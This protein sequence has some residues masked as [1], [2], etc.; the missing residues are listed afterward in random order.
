MV[1]VSGVAAVAAVAGV[2][3]M[4]GVAG[5][6]GVVAVLGRVGVSGVTRGRGLVSGDCLDG[7]AR[8][9][10]VTGVVVP[11]L[12]V[13]GVVPVVRVT[14]VVAVVRRVV[15]VHRVEGV[16]VLVTVLVVHCGFRCDRLFGGVDVGLVHGIAP[17]LSSDPWGQQ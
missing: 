1:A 14:C 6:L 16:T 7:V 8:M 3:G 17:G 5:V 4:S 15:F 13:T 10:G 12:H 11:V 2:L 9:F